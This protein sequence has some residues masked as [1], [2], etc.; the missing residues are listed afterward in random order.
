MASLPFSFAILGE[1]KLFFDSNIFVVVESGDKLWKAIQVELERVQCLVEPHFKGLCVIFDIFKVTHL[2]LDKIVEERITFQFRIKL[3]GWN[4]Q[5][6]IE[7]FFVENPFKEL[8]H[9]VHPVMVM[10]LREHTDSFIEATEKVCY[11]IS[12][13]DD[14]AAKIIEVHDALVL[15]VVLD[16]SK[17]QLSKIRIQAT[18][19]GD[20]E[21]SH[22]VFMRVSMLAKRT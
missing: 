16:K 12:L 21:A 20:V 5:I 13:L 14:V 3:V 19:D 11:A 9:L 17:E 22:M 10:I 7:E 8:E 2:K 15:L 6:S 4:Q 18:T 1:T